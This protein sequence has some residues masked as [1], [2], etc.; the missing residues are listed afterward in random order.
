MFNSKYLHN[1]ADLTM[2]EEL[3]LSLPK[4]VSSKSNMLL[5]LLKYT[6][7]YLAWFICCRYQS[8]LRCCPCRRE[9]T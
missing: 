8:S 5:R 6:F 3:I 4:D 1:N 2:I 7:I 9:K